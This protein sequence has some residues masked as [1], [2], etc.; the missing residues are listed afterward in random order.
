MVVCFNVFYR[1]NKAF[2]NIEFGPPGKNNMITDLSQTIFSFQNKIIL[3]QNNIMSRKVRHFPHLSKRITELLENG[4]KNEKLK[5][6]ENKLQSLLD[7]FQ[8][9]FEDLNALK[10]CFAFFVDPFHVDVISDGFPVPKIFSTNSFA[11]E[12][13]LLQLKEDLAIKIS[14]KSHSIIDFWKQVP[15]SKYP[16]LK[17]ICIRLFSIFSTMYSCES[18]YS[19]MSYIR[20]Y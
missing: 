16:E 9:R 12:I 10:P 13:E 2:A 11:A 5:E 6:Y 15:E 19:I 3:F 4:L 17:K 7:Y 20:A 18:L 8:A 1:C 14:H